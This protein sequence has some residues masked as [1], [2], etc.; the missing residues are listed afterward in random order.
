M[1]GFLETTHSQT[2]EGSEQAIEDVVC[3]ALRTLEWEF[4]T[5]NQS[6][7]TGTTKGSMTAFKEKFS[8]ER[9]G[10]KISFSSKN[11]TNS[12]KFFSMIEELGLVKKNFESAVIES[13]ESEFEKAFLQI[14]PKH[15]KFL[16]SAADKV[17]SRLQTGENV[18]AMSE[19]EFGGIGLLTVTDVRVISISG[20]SA[21]YFH[22]TIGSVQSV[23]RMLTLYVQGKQVNFPHV[24]KN[25]IEELTSLISQQ[26]GKAREPQP[27]APIAAPSIDIASQLEKLAS[28]REKGILTDEEFASQKAKLLA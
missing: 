23:M 9:N 3:S 25:R 18:L 2:Y 22:D 27:V 8:I 21:D 17:K 28:L 13:S 14:D 19:Y 1:A 26:I 12:K 6:T 4:K 24:A 5:E 20:A 16:R 10:Q 15:Q 7:I 11:V